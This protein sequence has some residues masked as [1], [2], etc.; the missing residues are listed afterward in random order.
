MKNSKVLEEKGGFISLHWDGTP[1]EESRLKDETKAPSDVFLWMQKRK[2]VF[3][4]LLVNTSKRR[5]L[6]AKAY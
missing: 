3:L 6:F 4:L 5:V 2:T 1:E